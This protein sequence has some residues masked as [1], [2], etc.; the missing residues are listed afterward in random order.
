MG[1]VIPFRTARQLRLLTGSARALERA[2]ERGGLI[3]IRAGAYVEAARAAAARP[4]AM[5]RARIA[6]A[7]LA[8]RSEPLF[9]HESAAVLQEIPLLGD[10]PARVVTS[11]GPSG[12]D[13]SPDV[14]RVKRAVPMPDRRSLDGGLMCTSAARTA[15]DI[16]AARGLLAGIVAISHV[17]ASGVGLD[18][19]EA[20]IDRAGR[21]P[22]QRRALIALRRSDDRVESTLET[23]I[24]VRCQD[25]CFESPQ[26][27][28]EIVGIDGGRY[29]VDFSWD[30]GRIVLEADG[31]AKYVQRAAELDVPVADVVWEE[32]RR[33][34]AIRAAG[35]TR[36]ARV[37]WDDAWRGAGLRQR[38]DALGVPRHAAR[39][40]S[41]LTF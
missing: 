27:Q 26:L 21:F 24:L 40:P 35:A 36:F 38:L 30:E 16:A 37:T 23:L 11:V 4:D 10:I 15:I 20:V 8:A 17:R 2:A 22:G 31:R 6:A 1:D 33:E 7:R 5:H 29:R 25:L 13:S 18:E 28:R 19:F 3:R 41:P 9:S 12:A 32:K 14:E 39:C 34:D